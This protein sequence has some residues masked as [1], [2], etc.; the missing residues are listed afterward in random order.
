MFKIKIK[1]KDQ[2]KVITG[3]SKGI[4]G[5]VLKVFP[6][7]NKVIISGVNIMKKH[8]KS[9]SNNPKGGIISK[10][11]PIDISNVS[12]LDPKLLQPTKIKYIFKD[13][14]KLRISK[15]SGEI[16]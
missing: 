16:L 9:S 12:I 1:K 15:K 14:K 7:K 6:K 5:E 8:V 10:E 2:V 11:L 4:I 13:N 3:K